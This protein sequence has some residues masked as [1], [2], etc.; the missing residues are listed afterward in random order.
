MSILSNYFDKVYCINL[1]R[2]LD[3]W[4]KVTNTFNKF[5]FDEVERFEAVDGKELDLSGVP[6][7][8]NLLLGELGLLET[9]INFINW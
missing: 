7:N 5:G 1:K 2:R 4:E 8:S 3:R 6:H 9:N